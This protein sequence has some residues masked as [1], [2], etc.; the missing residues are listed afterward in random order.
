MIETIIL[1]GQREQ[2]RADI[3]SENI[4]SEVQKGHSIYLGDW[5]NRKR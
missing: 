1:Y 3:R 2:E 5:C 4:S